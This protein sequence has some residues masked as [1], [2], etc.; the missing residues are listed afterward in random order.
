VRALPSLPFHPFLATAAYLVGAYGLTFIPIGWVARPLVATAMALGVLLLLTRLATRSWQAAG[1]VVAGAWLILAGWGLFLLAPLALWLAH[2]L[3]RRVPFPSLGS[4]TRGLNLVALVWLSLALVGAIPLML[5]PG[6]TVEPIADLDPART[7]ERPDIYLLLLDGYARADTLASVG[8]DNEPFLTALEERGFDVHRDATG[9][10]ETTAAAVAALVHGRDAH[11]LMDS[12]AAADV[13]QRR[14]LRDM[15]QAAPLLDELRSLGYEIVTSAPTYGLV[16]LNSADVYLDDG[17]PNEFE[18]SLLQDT[19]LA[20]IIT[21]L[22]P[23]LLVELHAS[24]IRSNLAHLAAVASD[25]RADPTFMLAHVMSPHPPF[26]FDAKG[27]PQPP[28]ACYPRDCRFGQTR[29][30]GISDEEFWDRYTEQ[31]DHVNGLVLAAIDTLMA[32]PDAVIV[33]FS[34]HGARR[35]PRDRDEWHRTLF[36]ART[37]GAEGAY[38]GAAHVPA[39]LPVIMETYFGADVPVVPQPT[40]P[41]SD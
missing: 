24:R 22:A 7:D 28:I 13:T 32:D 9:L 26:A 10:Y 38:D 29:D 12:A 17:Q 6:L 36:A 34:D 5:Q 40:E 3:T 23:D 21:F 31:L 41:D 30:I 39:V 16:T 2:R 19:A 15:I 8:Y 20:G 18:L 27:D 1:L 11:E 14:F 25:D 33:V 4:I 37:P 35:A